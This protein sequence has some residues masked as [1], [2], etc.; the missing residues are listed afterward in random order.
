M[1][2]GTL[3][4]HSKEG[5][6]EQVKFSTAVGGIDVS[7]FTLDAAIEGQDTQLRVGNDAA[8]IAA[9]SDWRRARG[10]GRVGLEA[11]G[12]YERKI[13][14]A[15][16]ADGIEV[17]LHQPIEVKLYGRFRRQHA[18]TDATDARLIAAATRA[19]ERPAKPADPAIMALG[20]RLT[21]YEQITDQ[22]MELRTFKDSLSLPDLLTMMQRQID[23]LAKLKAALARQLISAITACSR[24]KARY[25]LLI[26][27]PGIGPIVAACLVVRMPELGSMSRGQ[28]ASLIGVAPHARDS[29]RWKGDRFI[30]G[31]RARPRRMLYLAALAARRYDKHLNAFANGLISKG[32][33]PKLAIIA[34]MRK[35]I[36]AA[37]LVLKRAQPWT[38]QPA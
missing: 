26:S 7:K 4:A 15:L 3:G 17:V 23:D 2:A 10:V 8:G 6:M 35:L 22:L 38:K 27:L 1:V 37:N 30:S 13:R 31:G 14:A 24:L 9:V 32:K 25:D 29:G 20:E 12:G 28:A 33:P 11:T 18:K 16:E 36:E 21:V 34:V 5:S 19:I